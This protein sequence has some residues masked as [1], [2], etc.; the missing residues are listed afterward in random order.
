MVLDD[1]IS[2]KKETV[3]AL[4]EH[5]NLQNVKKLVKD[6]PKTRGFLKPGKFSLIAEMKKAS[7]SAGVLVDHYQPANLARAYE[8]AGARALS[9][10]TD[11]PF[12]QGRLEHLSEAKEATTIPV[13]RKDFII[14]EAQIYESRIG[15]ADA[16]LLIVRLLTDAELKAFL[17][18]ARELTLNCL[19]ETHNAAEVER[20]LKSGANFIGINN[21]DLDTLQVDL[22]TTLTLL[23]KYP[24]L[25][26]RL[27]ISESGISN[28]AEVKKLKAKGASGILVGESLLKS[29]DISA[30]IR[31]LLS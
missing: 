12:F 23:A 10:L 28:G 7:P 14:D 3:A 5:F 15:G 19:V 18:L 25:K 24:E 21:R 16:I 13:L 31:E 29:R 2:A 11:G 20:A 27:V 8:E 30:K 6:L 1:I 4:K 17:S 9:V 22:N 26:N